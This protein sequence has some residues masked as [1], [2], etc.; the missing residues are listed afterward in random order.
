MEPR[1]QKSEYKWAKFRLWMLSDSR[2]HLICLV[3]LLNGCQWTLDYCFFSPLETKMAFNSGNNCFMKI[4]FN[5]K[6][7]ESLYL[8]LCITWNYN[9]HQLYIHIIGGKYILKR[10]TA[11]RLFNI[12]HHSAWEMKP[13]LF[14]GR[15]KIHAVP[16][17]P[18]LR[19]SS[20][21]LFLQRME[22]YTQSKTNDSESANQTK[23]QRTW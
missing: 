6:Y 12:T 14:I 5:T 8:V 4:F 15:K 23:Q 19:F 22:I 17:V 3:Y 21:L 16:N 18:P 10:F 7:F 2:I 13:F 1:S 11:L 20:N 9:I